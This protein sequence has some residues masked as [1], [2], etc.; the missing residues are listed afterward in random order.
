M[1]ERQRS[2]VVAF[3]GVLAWREPV[4]LSTKRGALWSAKCRRSS[5]WARCGFV[6]F[7]VVIFADRSGCSDCSF[8]VLHVG[9]VQNLCISIN[10]V[11]YSLCGVPLFWTG[12]VLYNFPSSFIGYIFCNL[13]TNG[14][15]VFFLV[16]H[17][18]DGTNPS[19]PGM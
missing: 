6:L 8:T 10:D 14:N 2:L 7:C 15:H 9:V 18:V 1:V 11:G 3:W 13:K 16:V 4:N 5:T 17:T 19:P 12:S